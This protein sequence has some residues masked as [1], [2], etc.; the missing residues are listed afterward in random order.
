MDW[1]IWGWKIGLTSLPLSPIILLFKYCFMYI[2]LFHIP[3][4]LP[5]VWPYIS[6]FCP[7]AHSWS[8]DQPGHPLSSEHRLTRAVLSRDSRSTPQLVF[9]SG[10]TTPMT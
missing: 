5:V 9:V 7:F 10:Q 2:L 1:P 8:H 4:L 3:L 6:S